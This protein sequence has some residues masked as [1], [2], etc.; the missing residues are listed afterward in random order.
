MRPPAITIIELVNSVTFPSSV[1]TTF[2]HPMARRSYYCA[3]DRSHDNVN[4]IP[5]EFTTG[6]IAARFAKFQPGEMPQRHELRFVIIDARVAGRRTNVW[7][8]WFHVNA[9][10]SDVAAFVRFMLANERKFRFC[11]IDASN[12]KYCEPNKSPENG[13]SWD[14][15]SL[16]NIYR[17]SADLKR[18]DIL[19]TRYPHTL[20]IVCELL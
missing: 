19:C 6:D 5:H 4:M 14:K 17:F 8:E 16:K 7:Y 9:M 18:K 13:M 15:V 10:L 2:L 11:H 1:M 20:I 12:V 3:K